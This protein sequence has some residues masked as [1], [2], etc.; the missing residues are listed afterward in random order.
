MSIAPLP[1]PLQHLGGRRFSFYPAIRNI[2]H[3]EWLYRR[4]TWSECVVANMRTG[5]ELCVPRI[6]LGDVSYSDDGDMVVALSRELES[7]AGAV[8][9]RERAVIQFPA[10]AISDVPAVPRPGHLAPVVNIR[11][12]AK[13]EVRGWRWIGA[14]AVLGAVA[15]AIVADFAHQATFH[16][17]PDSFRGHRAYL[18]LGPGD[19]YAAVVRRLGAPAK[20]E[21]LGSGAEAFRL[22]TYP[23]RHYAVVL[24]GPDNNAARYIGVIDPHGRVL[25]SVRLSDGR[26][27]AVLLSS[28]LAAGLR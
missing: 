1:T 3:N 8:I 7:R 24:L 25:D 16:Q 28:G 17:R 4:A 13:S 15:F 21:S 5:E 14:A 12:E 19:D 18:Q 10:P 9:P 2:E 20:T 6:F 23:S 11:L 27:S 26:S 22:L